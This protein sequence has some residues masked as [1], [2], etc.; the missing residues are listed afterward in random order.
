[1]SRR[2]EAITFDVEWSEG[3]KD[4]K[5]DSAK[6]EE[7][8]S[9]IPILKIPTASS[10]SE[11]E[12]HYYTQKSMRSSKKVMINEDRNTSYPIDDAAQEIRKSSKHKKKEDATDDKNSMISEADSAFEE[13][14]YHKARTQERLAVNVHN[15]DVEHAD[16]AKIES[17]ALE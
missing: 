14:P 15:N 13:T 11:N 9:M 17:P 12:K 2:R 4:M 1:M 10:I 6:I 8:V 5:V 7:N 3:R 16:S